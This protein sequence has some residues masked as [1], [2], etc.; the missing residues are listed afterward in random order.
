M[1]T[2][3]RKSIVFMLASFFVIS[4]SA[5][6]RPKR[7]KI[8]LEDRVAKQTEIIAKQLE[9]TADQQ[10]KIQEINLKYAQQM[11]ADRKAVQEKEAKKRQDMRA[12]ME[13]QIAAKDADFKQI[14]TPEQYKKWQDKQAEM[15]DKMTDRMKH[16]DGAKNKNR[17][18]NKPEKVK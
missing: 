5:Q 4:L 13:S 12:K 11:E 10:A 14:L 3:I 2:L 15:K 7:E 18:K 16:R 17:G 6:E 9:L 8:S 1:K